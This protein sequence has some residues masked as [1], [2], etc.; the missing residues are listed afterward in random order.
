MT[1]R[2]T[3]K[4]ILFQ[5]KT[6]V[7]DDSE[8]KALKQVREVIFREYGTESLSTSLPTLVSEIAK[9]IGRSEYEVVDAIRTLEQDEDIRVIE[10]TRF[11]SLLDYSFSPYSNWFWVSVIAAI[12]SIDLMLVTSGFG[13]YL[14]YF[15]GSLLLLFLP[16]Y[17]ITELIYARREEEG[18]HQKEKGIGGS[19]LAKQIALSVGLSLVILPSIALIL[20]YTPLGITLVPI[21]LSLSA[22]TFVCLV[23]ALERRYMQYKLRSYAI[24]S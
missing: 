2:A 23:S 5:R 17:S 11:S 4:G 1:N 12:V 22:I 6:K 3:S 19:N 7:T 8:N 21:V 15:F 20:N 16:G 9:R 24:E 10:K 14:R 18:E 13:L